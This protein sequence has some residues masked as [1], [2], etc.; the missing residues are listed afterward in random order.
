MTEDAWKSGNHVLS[1]ICCESEIYHLQENGYL[2]EG[3]EEISSPT[4]WTVVTLVERKVV[5][6]VT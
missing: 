4:P 2:P 1:L 3:E 6:I 5:L